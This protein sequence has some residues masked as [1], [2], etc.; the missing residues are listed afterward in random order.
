MV[1]IMENYIIVCCHAM[2]AAVKEN[3]IG[4]GDMKLWIGDTVDPFPHTVKYCPWCGTLITF[5]R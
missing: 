3:V 4:G 2:E 1:I 5:R